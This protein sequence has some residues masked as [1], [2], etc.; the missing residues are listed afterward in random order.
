MRAKTGKAVDANGN[1]HQQRRREML[2]RRIWDDAAATGDTHHCLDKVCYR[3]LKD[4]RRGARL[5]MRCGDVDAL[6]VYRCRH[7]GGYHLTSRLPRAGQPAYL[8]I[9]LCIVFS[10]G[11]SMSGDRYCRHIL[12]GALDAYA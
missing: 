2:L 1:R 5:S 8:K 7:C 6:G 9:P 10:S 11:D 12:G 4:A 3:S